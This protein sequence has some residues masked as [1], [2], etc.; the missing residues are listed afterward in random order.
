MIQA[1]DSHYHE[2][3]T[4]HHQTVHNRFKRNHKQ[5]HSTKVRLDARALQHDNQQLYER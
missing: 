2:D 4:M 3:E 5:Y 1:H